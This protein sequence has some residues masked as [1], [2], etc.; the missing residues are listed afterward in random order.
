MAD[1]HAI[2]ST[3]NTAVA[4]TY[5]DM[6]L[7]MAC[8]ATDAHVQNRLILCGI[9]PSTFQS[10]RGSRTRM[11]TTLVLNIEWTALSMVGGATFAPAAEVAAGPGK[12]HV[13]EAGA[14]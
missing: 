13:L 3:W 11:L 7:S 2:Q 10:W 4:A 14:A 12:V 8:T 6:R 9:W 5:W 1:Q